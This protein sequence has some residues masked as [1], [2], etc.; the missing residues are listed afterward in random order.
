MKVDYHVYSNISC[1]C[2]LL[3]VDL[4]ILFFFF[5]IF[6]IFQIKTQ[7]KQIPF[8]FKKLSAIM[9]LFS[10]PVLSFSNKTQP[11]KA[12]LKL[13]QKIVHF[14]IFHYCSKKKNPFPFYIIER[15]T[16]FYNEKQTSAYSALS[17][18]EEKDIQVIIQYWI[19]ILH[20][21]FGWINDFD[22]L[23]VDYV[24][25]FFIFDIFRSSSKLLKSFNGHNH[26][27]NSIDY[28]T[29][30]S[31]QFIYSGSTDKTIHIWNIED[32]KQI[33]L[34]NGHSS[35]VYCVKFSHYYYYNQRRHIIC[36]SSDDNTI[37]FWDV[38]HNKQLQIL[39]EHTSWV[40][41]IEFSQFNNGRYLCSG[42]GDNT[43]R[44]WDI[45]TFKLLNIFNGHIRGIYCIDIS[46]SLQ[47]NDNNN[48]GHEGSVSIIKYGSNE[49]KNIILSGSWD[50]SIRLWDI[51]SYQQIQ[52]FNGHTNFIS[53]V[54]YSPF[55]IKNIN[56]TFNSNVICS[57]S[58]DGTIRFWDIRKNKDE[59]YNIVNTNGIYSVKFLPL[60]KQEYKRKNRND[61]NYDI[62]AHCFINNFCSSFKPFIFF[63]IL[64]FTFQIST[65]LS[66]EYNELS[67]NKKI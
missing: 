24:N 16:T 26:C 32:N 9:V 20:I 5:Q 22:K 67:S 21:K 7:G 52:L 19:R 41:G 28:S 57:G 23:I 31:N 45:E 62:N 53:S 65:I 15:M 42:S 14:T 2:T 54:E 8:Y 61:H 13:K 12:R 60:K 37:R 66:L 56:E 59:L 29:F 51:R 44:L 34:F 38:K 3:H 48:I 47:N 43:I 58:L 33:K 30:N 50:K 46:S 63:Q 36:S 6:Q 64:S 17:E 18:K 10:T 25:T 49:L 4:I 27:V 35:F 11:R 1:C 55:I 40:G 39:N